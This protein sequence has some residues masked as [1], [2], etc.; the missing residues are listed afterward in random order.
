M[1]GISIWQLLILLV[2]VVLLFGTK[3]LKNIGKDAGD[4]V[5]GFKDAMGDGEKDA[6]DPQSATSSATASVEHKPQAQPTTTTEA[7][8]P[9]EAELQKKESERS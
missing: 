9:V 8:K 7:E 1:G 5:K 4:A 2:I 3:K 6:A